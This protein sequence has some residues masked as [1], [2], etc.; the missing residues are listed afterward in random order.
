MEIM[1]QRK[2]LR[3]RFLRSRQAVIGFVI[4]AMATLCAVLAP[5]ITTYTPL[6]MNPADR[7][8]P[9]SADHLIGTDH[10]GRDLFSRMVFGIQVSMLMGFLVSIITSILGVMIGLYTAYYEKLDH[11]LMRILDGLMAFPAILLAIAIVAILGPK[12]YNVVLALTIVMT[13]Y[14]ARVVRSAALVVKEQTYIE[15]MKAMGASS[16]RI[17]WRHMFPNVTSHL[18]IQ[19]TLVFAVSI[20]TEAALSFLG[21]GVPAPA[22]SLGNILY[23]G[24]NVIQ[25]AWW[26]TLYPGIA[27]VL[28]VLGLNLFGDGLRDVL[29]PQSNK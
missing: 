22:P 16:T 25:I 5:V 28:L 18:I 3:R 10:L 11:W 8:Q 29:D 4:I 13:P 2:R 9:P 17:I 15:A 6:E 26:V 27:V 14:I 19:T 24:K 7:L 21:A 23:D 1:E 12:T 20:I